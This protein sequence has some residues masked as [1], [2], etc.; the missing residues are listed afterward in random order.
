MCQEECVTSHASQNYPQISSGFM[1][2]ALNLDSCVAHVHKIIMQNN[3]G[4]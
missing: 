3:I 2:L 1:C 4:L